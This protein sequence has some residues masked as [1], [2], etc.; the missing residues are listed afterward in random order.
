MLLR[1]QLIDNQLLQRLALSRCSH[2]AL[3][4][5][6]NVALNIVLDWV[7]GNGTEEVEE[8]GELLGRIEECGG[9]DSVVRVGVDWDVDERRLH[10][11]EERHICGILCVEWELWEGGLLFCAVL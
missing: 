5:L 11:G 9:V 7:E 8:L 10:I 2:L 3:A 4:D 6:G 1:L